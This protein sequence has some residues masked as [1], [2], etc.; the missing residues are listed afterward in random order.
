[1]ADS[2]ACNRFSVPELVLLMVLLYQYALNKA[3]N[4]LLVVSFEV[5]IFIEASLASL[6]NIQILFIFEQKN[7]KIQYYF[8]YFLK[9]VKKMVTF[10]SAIIKSE[11]KKNECK[12]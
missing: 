10:Y 12:K 2:I 1:M 5:K 4:S 3:S 9:F 7:I 11:G 8:N 6:N